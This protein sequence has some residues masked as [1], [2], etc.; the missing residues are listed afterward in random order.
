MESNHCDNNVQEDYKK[1]IAE[2][3]DRN[4]MHQVCPTRICSLVPDRH[5][6]ISPMRRFS[7]GLM[8]AQQSTGLEDIHEED[9][10]EDGA[11]S[12][13]DHS[14][15]TTFTVL[16]SHTTPP[17]KQNRVRNPFDAAL[18][19]RLHLPIFSPS[20][21]KRVISPTQVKY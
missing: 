19:K 21:F 8:I 3:V 13:L 9:N 18:I 11:H 16:P 10:E 14:L 7:S 17:S 4:E 20:V 5:H 15:G 1:G 6:E 12:A 2:A